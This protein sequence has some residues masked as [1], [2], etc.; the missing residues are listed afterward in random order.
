[1]RA[2]VLFALLATVA[3]GAD[4]PGD[5]ADDVLDAVLEKDTKR[6]EELAKR[7][8]PDPWLVAEDLCSR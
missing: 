7:D 6:L 8:E 2:A 3:F 1:M 5:I 4:G